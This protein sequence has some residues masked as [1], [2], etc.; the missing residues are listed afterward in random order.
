MKVNS[1]VLNISSCISSKPQK[2][3]QAEL[4]V[5]SDSSRLRNMA[6]IWYAILEIMIYHDAL[7]ILNT[8]IYTIKAFLT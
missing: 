8:K 4:L 6:E 2:F 7:S 5:I 3:I 1:S